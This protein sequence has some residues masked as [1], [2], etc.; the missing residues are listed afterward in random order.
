MISAR[1]CHLVAVAV[2]SVWGGVMRWRWMV[3]ISCGREI[4]PQATRASIRRF[5]ET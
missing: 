2:R 5:E 3:A 1:C 4:A